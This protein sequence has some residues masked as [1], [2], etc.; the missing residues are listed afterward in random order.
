MPFLSQ[1]EAEI[2]QYEGWERKVLDYL[3]KNAVGRDNAVTWKELCEHLGYYG[4]F[5]LDRRSFNFGL[6]VKTR[7]NGIFICSSDQ[8]PKGYW[9]ASCMADIVDMRDWYKKRLESISINLNAL[10]AFTTQEFGTPEPSKHP[11]WEKRELRYI[12]ERKAKL[13][14][15]KRKCSHNDKTIEYN[16]SNGKG[17]DCQA[18]YCLDYLPLHNIVED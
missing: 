8:K 7:E 9:I 11:L 15:I 13:V 18:T 12:K 14:C 4:G 10:D 1:L 17:D 2:H 16:C 5:P 6:I 3:L